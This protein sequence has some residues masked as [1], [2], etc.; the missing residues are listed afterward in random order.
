M[1]SF[2]EIDNILQMAMAQKE[3]D[4]INS[5][6]SEDENAENQSSAKLSIHTMAQC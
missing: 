3:S 2:C 4:K 6:Q 5:F 1:I